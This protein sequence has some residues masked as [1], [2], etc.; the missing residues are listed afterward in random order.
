VSGLVKT[1]A[2]AITEAATLPDANQE[3]IGT[4]RCRITKSFVSSGMRSTKASAR[5]IRARGRLSI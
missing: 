3:Q 4:G 1:L 5:S 2:K